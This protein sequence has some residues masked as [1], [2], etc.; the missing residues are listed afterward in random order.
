MQRKIG[1]VKDKEGRIISK[2]ELPA[3]EHPDTQG[4]TMHEVASK[5][6]L[7]KIE[8]YQGPYELSPEEEY[9]IKLQQKI[10]EIAER[11]LRLRD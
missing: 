3:G 1:Y 8:V 10:R 4:Y 2:Y 5:A 6:E 9:E 7:D 11:E